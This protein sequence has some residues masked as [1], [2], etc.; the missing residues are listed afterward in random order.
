MRRPELARLGAAGVEG[1]DSQDRGEGGED[2][3]LDGTVG[4][5]SVDEGGER[6]VDRAEEG[7]ALEPGAPGAEAEAAVAGREPQPHHPALLRGRG[8][9]GRGCEWDAGDEAVEDEDDA[10][11]PDERAL[12]FLTFTDRR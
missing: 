6:L 3:A 12:L 11:E 2:T 1:A 9:R 5:H 7:G 4:S 10:V 8:R